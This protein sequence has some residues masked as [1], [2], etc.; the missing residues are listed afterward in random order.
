MKHDMNGPADT[1]WMGIVH[2]ALRRD[3]LRMREALA[4]DPPPDRR[5][6]LADHLAGMIDFL[7]AH[8]RRGTTAIGSWLH[9]DYAG[10]STIFQ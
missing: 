2:D 8:R 10:G 3:L 5:R 1:A 4:G 7:H 9:L 6:A